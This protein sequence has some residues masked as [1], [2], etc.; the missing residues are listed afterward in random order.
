MRRQGS[1][2]C[3][4]GSALHSYALHFYGR[5]IVDSDFFNATSWMNSLTN[6]PWKH[7]YYFQEIK[8]LTSSIQVSFQHVGRSAT[9]M[10]N[11]LANQGD[12]ARVREE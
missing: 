1:R 4:F 3:H 11:Y 9:G 5:L 6:H 8:W 7:F 10:A 12:A 2:T